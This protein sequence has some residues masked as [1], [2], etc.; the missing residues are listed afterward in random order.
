MRK[1]KKKLASVLALTCAISL[2]VSNFTV[3]A[4]SECT[5][6]ADGQHVLEDTLNPAMYT[7]CLGG[8]AEEYYNCMACNEMVNENGDIISYVA[9]SKPHTPGTELNKTDYT[10]C[11]GGLQSDYYICTG[12]DRE[13]DENGA[14]VPYI[15]GTGVHTPG[16]EMFEADYYECS[17]GFDVDFYACTKCDNYVDKDGNVLIPIEP[18]V[19]HKPGT[20]LHKADYTVEKGG[21]KT[22]YYLCTVCDYALDKDGNELQY[23]FGTAYSVELSGDTTAFSKEAIAEIVEI[24]KE[25]DVIIELDNGVTFTFAKGTM[26]EVKG[27]KEY[28]FGATIIKEF[29]DE[30]EHANG[31]SKENF[32]VRINFNYSGKL[33]GQAAIKIFVGTGNAGRTLYYSLINDDKSVTYIQSVVADKDGY[34]TV[35]QDHCS[36]YVVTSERIDIVNETEPPKTGDAGDMAVMIMLICAVVSGMVLMYAG[37]LKNSRI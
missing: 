2:N 18:T 37:R 23:Y 13:V 1:A 16:E 17:G 33:P 11:E 30:A 27:V 21:Y 28:D 19:A 24:N 14:E 20:E 3:F 10:V 15:E 5:A 29:A 31:V 6:S 12:C 34:I 22:D 26:S 4:A 36:D 9:P 32:V 35:K 25:K 8:I 7:E